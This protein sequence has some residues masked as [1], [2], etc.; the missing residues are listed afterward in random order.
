VTWVYVG[1]LNPKSDMYRCDHAEATV[2]GSDAGYPIGYCPC[3]SMSWRKDLMAF[4]DDSL[5]MRRVE[6]R[7][8]PTFVP[9]ELAGAWTGYA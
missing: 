1:A 5:G 9:V 8:I 4:P 6:A 3:C 7:P 2:R